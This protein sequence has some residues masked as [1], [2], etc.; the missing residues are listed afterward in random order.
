[1]IVGW[2][3][4]IAQASRHDDRVDARASIDHLVDQLME[5]ERRAV[6][7]HVSSSPALVDS[8]DIKALLSRISAQ[9]TR[10]DL[11]NIK[12]LAKVGY[13][14]Q[15]VTLKN[16]DSADHVQQSRDSQLLQE[17]GLAVNDVIDA[18]ELQYRE[19]FGKRI[20]GLI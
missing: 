4:A 5:L 1:V 15:S 13:L 16:F 6:G 3:V 2:L 7:Y 8:L 20:W 17:I 9:I 12:D 11:M 18:V 14:R 19:A 10:L